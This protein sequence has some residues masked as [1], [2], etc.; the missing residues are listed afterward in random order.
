MYIHTYSLNSM[1]SIL[2]FNTLHY[3]QIH[4]IL[5]QVPSTALALLSISVKVIFTVAL[6]GHDNTTAKFR[7]YHLTLSVTC[8]DRIHFLLNRGNHLAVL[9]VKLEKNTK[10]ENNDFHKL[11]S[12]CY[13][14][15]FNH[16]YIQGAAAPKNVI[17]LLDS[18]GSMTGSRMIIAQSTVNKILD[19]LTVNDY[20]N[21]IQV[22]YPLS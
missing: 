20:F 16:R 19:T 3:L 6:T 4:C 21:I 2:T 15:C 13:Y 11:F 18:S 14:Y 9:K 12:I 5:F 1:L 22:S 17:I 7:Q 10:I 8:I